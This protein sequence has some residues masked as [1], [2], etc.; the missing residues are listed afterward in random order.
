MI[1]KKAI[2]YPNVILGKNIIIEDFCIIGK[3]YD[4]IDKK[5]KTMIGD[6][7]KIRSHSIIYS[8][9]NIGNNFS[10]GHF[11]LIRQ[12]NQIGNNVSAGSHSEIGYNVIIEN[13]TRIHSQAFIS[14]YSILKEK[15]WI[16]PQAMLVNT[17]YPKHP[18]AKKN[19][20]G[21]FIGVNAKIGANSTIMSGVRIGD[22][23]LIGAG[24]VV[25]KNTN[26]N[27]IYAGV[28]AKF[29]RKIHYFND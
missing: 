14:E 27:S 20:K 5:S 26:R 16:G 2:I 24:S 22:N 4:L 23:C 29:I 25:L 19:L 21:P 18:N 17:K 9:N 15:S 8:G 3:P 13:Y 1:S 28:P 10:T 12:N 7:A 11:C 6:S